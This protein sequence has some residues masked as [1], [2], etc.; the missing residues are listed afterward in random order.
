MQCSHTV[1][2]NERRISLTLEEG[3]MLAEKG[4]YCQWAKHGNL[5]L[6]FP[7]F[8]LICSKIYTSTNKK[9]KEKRKKKKKR[10]KKPRITNEE[11]TSF[12]TKLFHHGLIMVLDP[13]PQ[14]Q[15]FSPFAPNWVYHNLD[16]SVVSRALESMDWSREEEGEFRE[17]SCSGLDFKGKVL[18]FGKLMWGQVACLFLDRILMRW[19]LCI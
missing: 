6:I 11:K 9:K 8:N 16:N 19:H 15:A 4:L 5:F 2:F 1:G 14:A 12:C 3:G 10:P 18:I 7:L 17:R 13:P